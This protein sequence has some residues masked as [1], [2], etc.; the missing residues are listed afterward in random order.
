MDNLKFT[1][2]TPL[3]NPKIIAK[4]NDKLL[5]QL[6]KQRIKGNFLIKIKNQVL[7]KLGFENLIK[8]Y[9]FH[10]SNEIL[11][12]GISEG[13]EYDICRMITGIHRSHSI[14]LSNDERK[15]NEDDENYR[16]QLISETIEKIKLRSYG[17]TFYRQKKLFQGEEFLYYPLPYELFAISIKISEILRENIEINCFQLYNGI[18]QNGLSALTLME[19]NLFGGAYSLCRSAIELY[20]QLL[21]LRPSAEVLYE[22]F[23]KF[24]IFEIEQSCKHKYPE[25]FRVLFKNRICQNSKSMANYLHFGWVDAIDKYHE[26]VVNSPYSIY[27]L[28]TYIAEKDRNRKTELEQLEPFYKSCH[29]YTHG[30]I[31]MSKYPLL[32]YFEISIMLYYIIHGTFL[33]LCE[34]KCVEPVINGINI[35]SMIERDFE[36]ICLQYKIRS[37]KMFDFYYQQ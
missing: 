18:V 17:S 25:E 9:N 26:I 29:A 16:Q 35:I 10:W 14:F 7:K 3:P 12:T 15:I 8:Y 2:L 21:I 36:I 34:Q 19:D 1:P 5:K 27:G 32:H 20:I 13:A 22:K 23:E 28:L 4:Q 33:L 24:R 31:Q 11:I 37:T 30:S 6:F